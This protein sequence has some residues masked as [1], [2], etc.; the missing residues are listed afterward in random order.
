MKLNSQGLHPSK[1]AVTLPKEYKCYGDSFDFIVFDLD[2]QNDQNTKPKGIKQHGK[3][4]SFPKYTMQTLS[5][6]ADT[7]MF[8]VKTLK[9]KIKQNKRVLENMYRDSD[10]DKQQQ[11]QWPFLAYNLG[12]NRVAFV[13]MSKQA[14]EEQIQYIYYL[15]ESFKFI[16]FVDFN[17]YEDIGFF[18]EDIRIEGCTN[19]A[20]LS[21]NTDK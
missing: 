1:H 9:P 17:N 15:P 13:D 20:F 14:K 12:Q 4:K 8:N 7:H 11:A 6:D 2:E 21:L 19:Y 5:I 18:A 16:S 10:Y 3:V